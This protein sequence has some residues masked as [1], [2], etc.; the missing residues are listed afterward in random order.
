MRQ[1]IPYFRSVFVEQRCSSVRF[2]GCTGELEGLACD[3]QG[4]V[5]AGLFEMDDHVTSGDV[6]I[7]NDFC[8][9][10][11]RANRNVPAELIQ[12][13]FL[14]SGPCPFGKDVEHLVAAADA[15]LIGGQRRVD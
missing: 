2:R 6:G 7:G 14:R 4:V 13:L 3:T 11:H 1:P 12:D 10:P 9:I 15:L 8:R 5:N